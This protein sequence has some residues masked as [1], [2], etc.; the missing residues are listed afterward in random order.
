ME[1]WIKLN[2]SLLNWEW[3]DDNLMLKAWI[4]ILL[5]ANHEDIRL[6]GNTIK[7]GSFCIS[8]NE[9]ALKI[10]CC[11]K[12]I[13]NIL[14]RLKNSGEIDYYSRTKYTLISVCKYDNYQT[15][16][17][18]E[19]ASSYTTK[20]HQIRNIV[21]KQVTQQSRTK[22]GSVNKCNS[23]N[24]NESNNNKVAPNYTTKS[25]YTRI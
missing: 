8:Q 25:H 9:M 20:S 15:I 7:R 10:G 23:N 22:K 3:W 2:R 6:K 11:R 18:N 16:F 13:Y 21:T 24:Y 14:K 17:S 4:Y 5:N 1:G 19:V 12:T